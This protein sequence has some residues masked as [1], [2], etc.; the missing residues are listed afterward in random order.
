MN[1]VRKASVAFFLASIVLLPV[2]A[3]GPGLVNVLPN[4]SL[5]A[6]PGPE[7][8][9]TVRV[10]DEETGAFVSG[11][12]LTGFSIGYDGSALSD[13]ARTGVQS[14]NLATDGGE[15]T[16][17][18]ALGILGNYPAPSVTGN[19]AVA[20]P[21]GPSAGVFDLIDSVSFWHNVP[22][23]PSSDI[24]FQVLVYT[25]KPDPTGPF[26]DQFECFVS[27]SIPIS[28]TSGWSQ[29]TLDGADTF[30]NG[31]AFCSGGT[32]DTL[33]SYQAS[34]TYDGYTVWSVFIQTTTATSPWH[35]GEPVYVD[36]VALNL[37]P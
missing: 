14:V 31:G 5:E 23:Q 11:D 16:P 18:S 13:Q 30:R 27:G 1:H 22:T 20:C 8:E 24:I 6:E 3:A 37:G 15:T 21:V 29:V 28:S 10:D 34:S 4:P 7:V 36:D 33:D 25:Q 19:C 2:A 17:W 12:E 26:L 32:A 35:T 9:V